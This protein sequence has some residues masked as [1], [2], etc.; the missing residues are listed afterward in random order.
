M[1][2][3]DRSVGSPNRSC[4]AVTPP[5]SLP[6]SALFFYLRGEEIPLGWTLLFLS[7]RLMELSHN[8]H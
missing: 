1:H 3:S 8:T 7:E 4:C 5:F 2:C 6:L